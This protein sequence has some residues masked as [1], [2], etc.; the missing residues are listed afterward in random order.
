[1]PLVFQRVL[2]GEQPAPRLSEQ[3]EILL[4]DL[5]RGP[6]LLHLLDEAREIPQIRFVRLIA[7]RRSELVVV[8]V[9]DARRREIAV[10]GFH[11]LVRRART[12]VQQ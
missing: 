10:E 6:D 3:I 1:M 9:L 4:I 8:V 11:V 5:Q 7:E 2:D 12:A